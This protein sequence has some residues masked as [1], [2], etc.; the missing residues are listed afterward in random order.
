MSYLDRYFGPDVVVEI[1][2]L[3]DER[4]EARLASLTSQQSKR[5]LTVREAGDYLGCGDRAIYGRIRRGRIPPG[6]VRHSGRS[7]LIDREALDRALDRGR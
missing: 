1:Q 7:V 3:V 6:A 4:V 5:W 2:R